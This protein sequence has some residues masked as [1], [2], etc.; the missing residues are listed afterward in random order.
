MMVHPSHF[1]NCRSGTD[2]GYTRGMADRL[3]DERWRLGSAL[4]VTGIVLGLC[5]A[6]ARA[7]GE[8]GLV[9][10]EWVA[11]DAC[12]DAAYV[13]REV[14]R[15]LAGTSPSGA[16]YLRARAEVHQSPSR[17][18][19]VEL[20]TTGPNGP[21][22][23]TVAA[24]S[25]RALADATALILALAVDPDRVA[26]NRPKPA[27]L[28]D[29]VPPAPEQTQAA[30]PPSSA[31]AAA[32]PVP[33][34]QPIVIAE[35]RRALAPPQRLRDLGWQ[36]EVSA[37]VDVGTL[38]SAAPGVAATLAWVPRALA[39]LRLE[40]A[41]NIFFDQ[42]Q[43]DPRAQSGQFALRT[44]DAGACVQRPLSRVE[45]S[46]CADAEVAWL[47][48]QGLYETQAWPGDAVWLVLRAR[49]M[50]AYR[51]TSTAAVRGDVGAGYD[52]TQPEFIAVGVGQGFI[53]QPARTTGRVSLG[54][55][56][57]F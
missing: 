24:E 11:P 8:P 19:N 12:P 49:A 44:F 14:D 51:L 52:T 48:A 57:R 7:S 26:A 54:L 23:R 36:F 15:L 5:A 21:G 18:W 28:Q 35:Q 34:P 33:A 38:P 16:P 50:A 45:V 1:S 56:I 41:A 40:V 4:A 17:A 46:A 20:R 27:P 43:D 32:S 25:C 30:G 53:H 29:S 47:L 3:R 55:E 10:L 6:T 13:G 22:F 9:A 31:T 2:S 42:A 37:V 39:S